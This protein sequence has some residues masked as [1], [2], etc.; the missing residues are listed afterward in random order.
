MVDSNGQSQVVE[1]REG[2]GY[3]VDADRLTEIYRK[4]QRTRLEEWTAFHESLR[5]DSRV[6]AGFSFEQDASD[7]RL[8]GIGVN[9]S[10]L[11]GA[12]VGCKWTEGRWPGKDALEFKSPG[13]RVRLNI[14]GEFESLTWTAWVRID[15]LDRLFNS[16]LLTDGFDPMRPHWQF[17]RDG[18][19]VLGVQHDARVKMDYESEPF[20]NMFTLGRWTHVATVYDGEAGEVRHFINGQHSATVPL[21]KTDNPKI[22]L[23][24]ITIGNW[25]DA[26]TK[27]NR[28]RSL[29][30]RIDEL[31]LFS[32][33]L[34]EDE[35]I[36]VYASSTR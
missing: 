36:R 3:F 18:S 17:H 8:I 2:D 21:A 24:N 27:N 33:A 10:P 25:V 20:M 19:L 15:A 12:I 29:N 4:N 11:D 6:V 13:D 1:L 16:L 30:G 5:T 32:T 23:G 7:R 22:T 14:P 9:G 31:I 26:S 28:V 34:N 35:I